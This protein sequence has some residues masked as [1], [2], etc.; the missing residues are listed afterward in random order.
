M[1]KGQ[2]YTPFYIFKTWICVFY[3]KL[4]F[5]FVIDQAFTFYM[6]LYNVN[7]ALNFG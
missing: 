7:I 3:M 4:D 2:I 1:F 6:L 5:F